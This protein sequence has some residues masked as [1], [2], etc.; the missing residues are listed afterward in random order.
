MNIEQIETKIRQSVQSAVEAGIKIEPN[1]WGAFTITTDGTHKLMAKC[2][3]PL[4][5]LIIDQKYEDY[6]TVS[7]Y[8][9]V[10]DII[11]QNQDWV[12]SFTLGF[13]KKDTV[14]V[15]FLDQ[16]AYN[17][18]AAFRKEILQ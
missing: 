2:C 8:Q 10:S 18:G 17:L 15:E 9:I 4:S 12:F 5:T 6:N 7:Y 1:Y 11:G 14:E 3:C 13:D 16:E